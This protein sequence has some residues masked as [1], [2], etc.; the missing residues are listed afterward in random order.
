[1]KITKITQQQKQQNRYSVFVDEKYAFSLSEAK[2]LESQLASGQELTREQV[3][4]Y[5]KLSADDKLYN[6]ALNYVALRPRS[7]WEV[8][9]YLR[10]KDSPAPLIEQITNK[11]LELGLLDDKKFAQMFVH[12]RALLRPTSRRK[13]IM[14]LR[15]KR[16]PEEVIQLTL[17]TEPTDELSALREIVAKKGQLTKY[18]ND[19]LKFMQYLA[20]QGF[21]YSDIKQVLADSSET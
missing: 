7:V 13:M 1:M 9:E 16:L 6:R 12:D 17:E 10:R 15:K 3:A 8:Q 5:K 4:E 19:Q 2:L 14:E 11:L 18:K 21:N 20:R